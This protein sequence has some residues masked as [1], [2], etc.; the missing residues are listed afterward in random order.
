MNDR[1]KANLDKVHDKY[2]F[3]LNYLNDF[4]I[5]GKLNGFEIAGIEECKWILLIIDDVYEMIKHA[6]TTKL[7]GMEHSRNYQLRT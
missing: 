5:I 1:I 6:E 7:K 2:K 3:I 4:Q